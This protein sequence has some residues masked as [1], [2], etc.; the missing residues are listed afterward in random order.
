MNEIKL[1]EKVSVKQWRS[2]FYTACLLL[3]LLSC[4]ST[5]SDTQHADL[6]SLSLVGGLTGAPANEPVELD[7]P[8]IKKRGR[9]IAIVDN[10]STSYFIY[11]GQAM[12]YEY[13]LLSRL[14]QKLGV[15]LEIIIT[16]SLDEALEMLQRGEGDIIA[17]N[18]TITKER[19]EKIAFTLHHNEVRQMLV[20]R[21]PQSWRNMTLDNID[22]KLIR[23][24]LDLAGK[25]VHVKKNSSHFSR[26]VNLSDEIG[27]DITIVEEDPTV[28]VEAL[29]KKVAN[30]DIDYTVADENVALLNAAYYSNLDVS[31]PVSFHQRIAWGVRTNAPDLLKAVNGWIREIRK[32]PDYAVIYNKYFKNRSNMKMLASSNYSSI[33]GS[34]ISPYDKHIKEAASRIG[35]DWRLLAAVVYQE[36]KFNPEAE[37]WMGAAGLMQLMPETA[38]IFGAENPLDPKQSIMAGA[39][40]LQWLDKFWTDEVPDPEERKKFVLASY[41]VGQ[42]HVLDA[43]KLARKHGRSPEIWEEHVAYFLEKKA[44]PAFYNDEVV[45]LGYCRGGEPVRYVKNIMQRQARYRQLIPDEVAPSHEKEQL[46]AMAK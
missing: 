39:N 29:I 16:T 46:L 12:G 35:W 4:K 25:E 40:Y 3:V 2:S 19:R 17:H 1:D 43:R 28:E 7:L 38:E 30:G 37:S 26:L 21:K 8:E 33:S 13:D 32:T 11:K 10:S 45:S 22:K 20:Q 9:L 23:N 5:N 42:G 24:P 34:Q 27:S 6:L 14:A 44:D 18:L 41:N 36:S 15:D 31:T